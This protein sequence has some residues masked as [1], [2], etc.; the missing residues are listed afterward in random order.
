[1]IYKGCTVFMEF[2][3]AGPNWWVQMHWICLDIPR[4]SCILC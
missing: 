2:V 4:P 3:S 1:M